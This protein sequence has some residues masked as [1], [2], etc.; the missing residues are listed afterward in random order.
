MSI[1]R[2]SKSEAV[3]FD[4]F[5]DF[6]SR[7]YES[8]QSLEELINDYTDIQ[9]K[10][11]KIQCQEHDCDKLVHEIMRKLNTSF[12]TPLDREDIESIGHVMDNVVDG[13]EA[14]AQCFTMYNVVA[15]KDEAKA[16]SALITRC[17]AELQMLMVELKRMKTSKTLQKLIIEINSIENEGDEIYRNALSALFKNESNAIDIIKWKDMYELLENT[18]DACEDVANIVEGV[19]MKHA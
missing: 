15:I 7:A 19:V 10:V 18:I 5:I 9:T 3:Y 16:M 6:A 2:V 13:I 8:A 17:T 14:A 12:V 11:E 1:F 4:L